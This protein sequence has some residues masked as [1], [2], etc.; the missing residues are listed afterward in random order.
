MLSACSGESAW[1][2]RGRTS[3]SKIAASPWVPENILYSGRRAGFSQDGV[4]KPAVEL[5]HDTRI[6]VMLDAVPLEAKRLFDLFRRGNPSGAVMKL[7]QIEA[8]ADWSRVMDPWSQFGNF[9]RLAH[10]RS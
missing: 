9:N 5:S 1:F 7:E 4:S 3:G 8:R 6:V 10:D 2:R